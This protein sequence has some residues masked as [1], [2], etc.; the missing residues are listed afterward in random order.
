MKCPAPAPHETE[1]LKVLSDYGIATATRIKSIDRIVDIAARIFD[2]PM[3]AVN[4]VAGADT[5]HISNRG[6]EEVAGS[7]RDTSFCGH[8]ILQDEVMVVKDALLDERFHDNPL[9]LDG[10]IRFYAGVPIKSSSGHPLGALCVVDSWPHSKCD[11]RSLQQLASLAKI[12]EDELELHRLELA[13][14]SGTSHLTTVAQQCPNAVIRIDSTRCIIDWNAAAERMFGYAAAAIVGS[15]LDSLLSD[16]DKERMN[17][18]VRR[19]LNGKKPGRVGIELNGVRSNG[20]LFPIEIFWNSWQDGE[21]L[22]FGCVVKDLTDEYGERNVLQHL[23]LHDELTDLP[24]RHLMHQQL[25]QL[26]S[27]QEPVALILTDIVG[28]ADIN[29]AMGQAVGDELLRIAGKRILAAAPPISIVA[30][31]APEQFAVLVTDPQ[32]IAGASEAARRLKAVITEPVKLE[33]GQEIS[34]NSYF[35][36]TLSGEHGKSADELI[37]NSELALFRARQDESVCTFTPSLRSEVVARRMFDAEL[38]R[39]LEEGQLALFYQPQVNISDNRLTGAEALIRWHHP[40]RSLLK[41]AAFLT[42]VE[43]GE[44]AVPVGSWVLKNACAQLAVWQQKAPGMSVSVNLFAEQ[45]RSRTLPSLVMETL[46]SHKLSP[47]SLEL[48]IA[49][50]IVLHDDSE[51]LSQL[52]ELRSLGVGISFDGFGTD[53]ASLTML[54]DFPATSI[55]IDRRFTQ[56]ILESDSDRAIMVSII[57]LAHELGLTV[58]A[59]GIESDATLEFLALLKCDKGQGYFLGK[60]MP[61]DVFNHHYLSKL[62][63]S[64]SNWPSSQSAVA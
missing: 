2:M 12:V 9:V 59:K 39:A 21:Q 40:K 27:N 13:A 53:F 17:I 50:N 4:I 42:Q 34:I 18:G 8:A 46:E 63:L 31:T 23:T 24:N 6:F 56:A 37:G 22:Q 26:L 52:K 43:S 62:A 55:Q 14:S 25:T 29:I 3:A 44:L 28:V 5:F 54:R 49:E 51:V 11:D 35:G 38:R 32:S 41:P 60:P 64:T 57:G 16:R 19:V 20:E 1:R 15:S 10:F 33:S 36:I 30:R 45:F 7:S 47:G 61:A 48:E 58:V